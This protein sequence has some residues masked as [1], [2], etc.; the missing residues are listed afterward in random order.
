M[1]LKTRAN[2]TELDELDNERAIMLYDKVLVRYF[3]GK[4]IEI[5]SSQM[6]S[7]LPFVRLDDVQAKFKLSNQQEIDDFLENLKQKAENDLLFSEKKE[8]N[9]PA[10]SSEKVI[11]KSILIPNYLIDNEE[12]R[13]QET[14]LY[15]A[16]VH[17]LIIDKH[18][19]PRAD[20]FKNKYKISG[21]SFNKYMKT[22]EERGAIYYL[23]EEYLGKEL[24][25]AEFKGKDG[26]VKLDVQKFNKMVKAEKTELL[27]RIFCFL[28]K[29]AGAKKSCFPSHRYM[30]KR[31][32]VILNNM[33]A[34]LDLLERLHLIQTKKTKS[35]DQQYLHNE[36]KIL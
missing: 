16:L 28:K 26:F 33:K 18:H 22:L 17:F 11:G 20:Y 9:P 10:A 36:Y 24:R 5:H 35:E 13:P 30:S 7:G 2:I 8:Q 4:D 25:I 21:Y 31:T 12:V 34:T 1:K 29:C 19:K 3:H 32:N 23:E 15:A 27:I 14:Y 6:Y